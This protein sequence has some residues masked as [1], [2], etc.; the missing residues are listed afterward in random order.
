M[1]VKYMEISP[2]LAS[3]WL[4][5]SKGNPRWETGKVVDNNRVNKIATDIK[6]GKWIPGN[7]S[8]AFDSN[9]ILV[10]GHHRLSAVVRANSPV[11][12]IVVT[13]IEENGLKHIDE[14]RSRT[15]AQRLGVDTH[16][17]AIANCRDW[18][19]NGTS[20][21]N[22]LTTEEV[23]VFI[24]SH[25]LIYDAI[26]ISRTGSSHAIASKSGVQDAILWA[27]EC[28]INTDILCNFIRCVNSG[29]TDGPNESAAIVLRNTLLRSVVKSRIDSV[30]IDFATQSALSDF[31]DGIPRKNTYRSNRGVY[32]DI[33]MFK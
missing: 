13:G 10:D 31:I 18:V 9:G 20:R 29:F 30:N 3:M 12:S 19:L 4:S 11:W 14:N 8:I 6:S 22:T 7:N 25:P 2:E 27:M 1:E 24:D 33:M 5:R 28:G 21:A 16:A 32:T 17:V 15:V 23:L 26:Q